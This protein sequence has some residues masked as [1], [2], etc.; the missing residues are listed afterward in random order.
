MPRKP[1]RDLSKHRFPFEKWPA[2]TYEYWSFVPTCAAC[3]NNLMSIVDKEPRKQICWK[4]G[5]F[6]DAYADIQWL[7]TYRIGIKC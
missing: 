5:A 6:I 7:G 3:G 4:C 2:S 1:K